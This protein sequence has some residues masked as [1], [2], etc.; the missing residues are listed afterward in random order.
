MPS[1]HQARRTGAAAAL[2]VLALPGLAFA[3]AFQINE[4]SAR[5]QGASFAGSASAA[6]DVTFATFN[7]AALAGVEGIE[8]GGNLSYISPISDGTVQTGPFAGQEVDADRWAVVPSGVGAWRVTEKLV[9]GLANYTPFGLKTQ[10][11]VNWAGQA[12]ARTSELRAVA[13]SPMVAYEVM[14]G[15]TFGAALDVLYADVR[16]TSAAVNLDGDD[17]AVSFRAGVHWQLLPTTSVGIA[18]HH[19]YDL[20]PDTAA[21]GGLPGK[22]EA[23]LPN[24][25]QAGVTHGF[26]DDFRVMLEGRWINWSVFDEIVITTPGLAGTPLG[27]VSDEQEYEDAFFLAAGAEYDLSE[28]LTLRGGIAYDDTPTTDAFRTPRVPDADRLWLS[29]GA[30]Y[31]V[32]E[33]MSVDFAYSYLLALEDAEVTLRNGPLAGTIVD[34][35]SGAHIVSIGGSIRF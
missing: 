10:Y 5:A 25:V 20:S 35:E 14:E 29:A 1:M 18:Y 22:A 3:G 9:L 34:Y 23:S 15:L 2:A 24:W 12:D 19:G 33:T 26:T 6:G 32:T 8:L 7:P 13:I 30:S 16:L 21:F 4:R 17:L 31:A 27:R 28:A 11:P